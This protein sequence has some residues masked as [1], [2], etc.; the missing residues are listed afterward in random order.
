MKKYFLS[1]FCCICLVFSL[2][3]AENFQAVL[4]PSTVLEGEPFVLH[5]INHGSEQ[6]QLVKMPENFVYQGSSQSTRIVNGD[7]TVSTG[8]RFIAP[9]PGEYKIA[10]LPV[11]LG[12]KSLYTPNLTLKVVK[13]SQANIGLDDVFARGVFADKRNV[14]YVGEEIP[15][16]V[17]LYY[18]QKLRIELSAYPVLD[19][20]KSVFR[21]FRNVNQENPAFGRVQTKR[22]VMGDK[23]FN[24][25]IFPTAFRPLAP[26][27]LVIK[28]SLVCNI[29]IPE[30]R[31]SSDPFDD[32]FG[33]G[34]TYRR[35]GRKL[36]ITL[37]EITVKPLPEAPPS[38]F[39]LGLTGDFTGK[40]ALSQN[41]V[42]A[43]EPISLDL[44]LQ[45]L[46]GA[47]FETLQTPQ[48]SL[49]DCRVYPGEVRTGNGGCV[50]SYAVVPLKA[51]NIDIDEKFYFFEPR[52]G[53][54]Q[55]IA[56]DQLLK[57]NPPVGKSV[58][59]ATPAAAAERQ[60]KAAGAVDTSAENIPRTT[61]LYC[62]KSPSSTL[63]LFYK[64]NQ[65][66]A[67]LLLFIAGPAI[68]LLFYMLGKYRAGSA[69][70]LDALRRERAG[71]QRTLLA[72][73]IRKTPD[74]ELPQ[75]VTGEVANFFCDRWKL[76]AGAT[77]EDIAQHA[78]NKLLAEVLRECANISYLPPAMAK[79]ALTDPE[80]IRKTILTALKILVLFLSFSLLL[81]VSAAVDKDTPASWHDALKAY[82]QGKYAAAKR[83]FEKYDQENP[84]DPNVYYNLGCIA[85][86]NNEPEMALYYL[87]SAGLLDPLD[88]AAYQNRNVMR[89][90]FFLPMTD[91]AS[92]PRELLTALRDRLHPKD[93]LVI[94]GLCWFAFF[95]LLTWRKKLPDTVLWSV[96]SGLV[97]G[98][99]L[100]LILLFSQYH[101]T[102][103]AGQAL[104]VAKNAEVFS[105]PGKHN[106][107]KVGA[108]PGG[109]PVEIVDAESDYSLVN[110]GKLTGWVANKNIRKLPV[111]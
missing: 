106:G 25:I 64:R 41:S 80:K 88:S 50:I 60:E 31:R 105:F 49:P 19:I 1:C 62:K 98:V 111:R 92:S 39:F 33:G 47:S 10:P 81:P 67:A 56:I 58:I 42:N 61:L 87:E 52:S 21:D 37:P 73:K 5:L 43:L 38:G 94:A 91:A 103:R 59:A 99:L 101:T 107:K 55:C 70:D 26:G 35:I 7:Q 4:E 11:N 78:E 9:A 36:M 66:W 27:K 75:L 86:A 104:V 2:S 40:A 74:G 13:D 48:I 6:P 51:G 22:D 30:K 72:E 15:L 84:A 93:F 63:Y 83:Y 109:T 44:T 20:G 12:K 102:Y 76:P 17:N 29:L 89:G 97:A 57:V 90:K 8:Y 85:E 54:Y 65:A 69:A 53:K 14:Y 95:I 24:T 28:G 71:Q 34:T 23:L 77:I 79:T 100:A 18:P 96:G 32:F 16:S 110:S 45:A 68:F 46:N 108:L 82:D 3:A